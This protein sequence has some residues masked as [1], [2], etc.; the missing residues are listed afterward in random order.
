[1]NRGFV[2]I[3]IAIFIG[4]G[5]FWYL[6]GNGITQDKQGGTGIDLSIEHR[7][8]DPPV[9]RVTEGEQVTF[10]VNT[11]ESGSLH[12]QGYE[13][14]AAV[15][16]GRTAEMKF[17]A[18]KAGTYPI[19]LHPVSSPDSELHVGELNVQPIPKPW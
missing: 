12:I 14:V 19:H 16:A 10:L 1:M 9:V 3:T 17:V 11:D 6:Q 2:I 18:D 8:I 13:V 7:Q 4:A 5:L 15:A